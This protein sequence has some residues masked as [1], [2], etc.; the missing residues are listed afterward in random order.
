M[1]W[2]IPP[3]VSIFHSGQ[4]D[5][6]GS[7]GTI[8]K[9]LCISKDLIRISKGVVDLGSDAKQKACFHYRASV[10][11]VHVV[12]AG[13]AGSVGRELLDVLFRQGSTS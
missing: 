13:G 6:N 5:T 9:V 3:P 7:S 11:P 2:E 12:L 8:H 1:A 4:S 10:M